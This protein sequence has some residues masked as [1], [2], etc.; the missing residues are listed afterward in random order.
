MDR[1]WLLGIIVFVTVLIGVLLVVRL[2][3]PPTVTPPEGTITT[4]Y[5]PP[6][7]KKPPMPMPPT[8]PTLNK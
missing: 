1:R 3:R 6:P 8:P 4:P 5:L 2:T 7:K